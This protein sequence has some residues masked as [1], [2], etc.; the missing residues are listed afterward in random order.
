MPQMPRRAIA[1]Q[2]PACTRM[3]SASTNS[4]L[5]RESW[6]LARCSRLAAEAGLRGLVMFSDPVPRTRTDGVVVMPGHIGTIYQ[7]SN[8]V[9]TN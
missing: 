4:A 3:N 2:A 1:K 7:A 9:Y 6:F 8:A 5:H